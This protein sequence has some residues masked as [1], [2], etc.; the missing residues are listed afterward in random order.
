M[1]DLYQV[2]GIERTATQE[3]IKAAYRSLANKHHP[4]KG[5]DT[6]LFQKI[7]E[8]YTILSD[9]FKKSE[10]DLTGDY[11]DTSDRVNAILI[12]FLMQS[13][14][15]MFNDSFDLKAMIS[16]ELMNEKFN[17]INAN[18]GIESQLKKLKA[19]NNRIKPDTHFSKRLIQKRVEAMENGLAANKLNIRVIDKALTELE[20]F[21]YRLDPQVTTNFG[22][23]LTTPFISA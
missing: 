18:N 8:A 14:D 13:I 17:N 16:K 1:S 11:V 19:V 7:N 12:Q 2:L 21:E 9:E 3:E 4:D 5:G 10:Y 20:T 6:E 15:Q 23:S 22:I